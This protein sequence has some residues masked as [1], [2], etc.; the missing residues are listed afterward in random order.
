MI[1]DNDPIGPAISS[2][3]FGRGYELEN[4]DAY[5][6][7]TP[8]GITAAAEAFAQHLDRFD[9]FA[10]EQK[11]DIM[12]ALQSVTAAQALW[13]TMELSVYMQDE[14]TGEPNYDR[15]YTVLH[16]ITRTLEQGA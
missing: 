13:F 3:R 7:T 11:R 12:I 8:A 5:D 6:L 14:R 4:T 15:F 1:P 16:N 9:P 2:K 10:V